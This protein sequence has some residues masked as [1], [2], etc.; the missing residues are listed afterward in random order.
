LLVTVLL[1]P[2]VAGELR[3]RAEACL[4]SAT[5]R[6]QDSYS[7]QKSAPKSGAPEDRLSLG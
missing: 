4:A 7:G 2:V 1:K 6:C 5:A 3:A